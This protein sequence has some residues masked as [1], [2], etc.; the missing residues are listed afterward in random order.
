MILT[1][2]K[3]IR[4]QAQY[5]PGFWG[6]L[7]NPFYFAR[8][9]LFQEISSLAPFVGGRIL[10][11]GCGLKPYQS[12]FP[13]C[14]YVGLEIERQEKCLGTI[15][16]YYYK[17]GVLPF[18]DEEF[19]SL[20]SSQVLEHVED[21]DQFLQEANRVLRKGGSLLLTV[22]FIWDEH[23]QPFDYRRYSSFGLVAALHKH[24]F[25]VLESRKT[26]ANSHVLF[27]LLA[28]Y[29]FKATRTSHPLLNEILGLHGFQWVKNT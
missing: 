26:L 28:V 29:L 16:D 5:N 14:T 11:V 17:G 2:L 21:S 27:Q 13:G 9:G 12:L 20:L 7:T 15:A 4:A 18:Q 24:R 8:C 6:V 23:E 19:D 3:R 25:K 22:P 1:K 10:D